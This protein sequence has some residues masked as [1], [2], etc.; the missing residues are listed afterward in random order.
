MLKMCVQ[1]NKNFL[2]SFHRV[3]L[4][5]TIFSQFWDREFCAEI[6]NKILQP[7][8]QWRNFSNKEIVIFSSEF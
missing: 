7:R 3:L 4:F 1:R 2:E 6:S 8:K 5:G